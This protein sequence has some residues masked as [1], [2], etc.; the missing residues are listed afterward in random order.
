MGIAG[1][2]AKERK[3]SVLV[4]EDEPSMR[5]YLREVLTQEGYEVSVFPGAMSALAY[6][7]KSE[8]QTDL[9]LTDIGLPGAS[10]LDLLQTVKMV[11]PELPVILL[12]GLYEVELALTALKNG[13]ADYLVK[14]VNAIELTGVVNNHLRPDTQRKQAEAHE[15][16][17]SLLVRNGRRSLTSE[18]V[19]QVFSAVGLKRSET[20]VHCERVSALAVLFGQELDLFGEQLLDLELA[21]LL[22]DIG[23]V[24]VPHNLLEKKGPLTPHERRIMELHP[25]IG[26][27]LL[28]GFPCL[29]R[30]AEVAR[31][32]HESFDGS[33]YPRGIRGE[34]IPMAARIFS[35]V[36]TFDAITSERPYR[37]AQ[38][39]ELALKEIE[40]AA[41]EQ[42]DPSLVEVFL[43]IG[44]GRLL[45]PGLSSQPSWTTR[46]KVEQL[47]G[48]P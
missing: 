1:Q 6:L 21:A 37:A 5:E 30:A 11:S 27:E 4:V 41:G 44:P 39:V 17:K 19:E 35:V 48:G 28:S 9:M 47:V 42:L 7:S 3:K 43:K 20:R 26:F 45:R 29:A 31:A 38:P 2:M 8:K 14:P 18:Q 22:H 36:D 46:L 15:I 40:G 34:Q 24:A 10:G 13:A 23:K 12:S 33:G 32:H 16:L 25:Q